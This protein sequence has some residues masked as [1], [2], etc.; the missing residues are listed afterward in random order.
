MPRFRCKIV[1]RTFS[2]PPDNLLPY[3]SLRT[4]LVLS[5]LHALYIQE[6]ALNT[7]VR[8]RGVARSALRSLR[9]RFERVV[10]VLRLPECEGA[11]R[12]AAFLEA[13]SRKEPSSL[14][15]LFRRWK[16]GEPKHS[17][18]GVYAR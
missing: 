1:R 2:V 14:L 11:S 13:L 12:A 16:E 6:I 4:A 17:V 18:V 9:T 7:L 3:C 15:A 5:L 8:T 10:S